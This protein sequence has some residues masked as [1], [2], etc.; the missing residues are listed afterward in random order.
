MQR[1]KEFAV[2][3]TFA[4]CSVVRVFAY[5]GYPDPNPPGPVKQTNPKVFTGYGISNQVAIDNALAQAKAACPEG[6]TVYTE[7]RDSGGSPGHVY[8]TER[9]LYVL[10][11]TPNSKP[12]S[13]SRTKADLKTD[14]DSDSKKISPGAD[15]ADY[16]AKVDKARQTQARI[17]E[18]SDRDFKEKVDELEK[19]QEDEN[20]QANMDWSRQ[21]K[22]EDAQK[23]ADDLKKL[24]D[25]QRQTSFTND[26]KN[27]SNENLEFKS[28]DFISRSP[29]SQNY[30]KAYDGQNAGNGLPCSVFVGAVLAKQGIDTS[31]KMPGDNYTVGEAINMSFLK[32]EALTK[33][34]ESNAPESQGVVNAL[35]RTGQCL[36]I[37]PTSVETGDVIQYWWKDPDGWHGHSAFVLDR[38]S[39]DNGKTHYKLHSVNYQRATGLR[40]EKTWSTT[41]EKASKIYTCRPVFN[42]AKPTLVLP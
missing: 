10:Y 26:V 27:V 35:T 32:G 37:S 31:Q 5:D 22:L 15:D 8:A 18:R 19:K 24:A 20:V 33:A 42:Q 40:V 4:L 9:A 34:V 3:M 13:D 6:W 2:F 25:E 12:A 23:Q 21:K 30:I 39:D 36:P 14:S 41:L 29:A 1:L 38:I 16:W 17:D 7:L 11:D 28:D